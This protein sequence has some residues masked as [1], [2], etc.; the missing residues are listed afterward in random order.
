MKMTIKQYADLV[1]VERDTIYKRILNNVKLLTGVT[2]IE[3]V[4]A[5]TILHVNEDKARG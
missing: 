2:K 5:I 1:G 4:G 3:K